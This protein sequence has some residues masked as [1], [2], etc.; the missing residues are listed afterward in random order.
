MG[1]NNPPSTATRALLLTGAR[2]TPIDLP[3]LAVSVNIIVPSTGVSVE[4]LSLEA[5]SSMRLA[6][7]LTSFETSIASAKGRSLIGVTPSPILYL[8]ASATIIS[9]KAEFIKRSS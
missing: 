7:S 4:R 3:L 1:T 6:T 8:T 5:S 9:S 2:A